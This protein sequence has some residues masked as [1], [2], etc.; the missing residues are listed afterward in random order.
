MSRQL[1]WGHRIPAYYY[2]DEVFVAETEEEA[3]Q[4]AREHFPDENIT[5]K[6]LKQDEDVLD[7]WF[8]S[9]L[10]PI[11]VFDGFEDREELEYY[12]PTSVLV[13]AWDIIFLWVARMIMAGYEWEDKRPF[14]KVY[15]TGM[16]RDKKRRKM[17]KSLGNS[18]DALGLIKEYGADAVRFGML[19][20]SPAGGDLLYD[21]KL[22]EQGSNFCNKMWN[23]LRLIKSWEVSDSV[24]QPEVNHL[25]IGWLEARLQSV[26]NELQEDFEKFR[27]SEVVMDLYNFIW[28]DFCSWFLELIKPDYEQP[29]DSKTHQKAIQL[30]EEIMVVLHPFMPFISEEI[31]HKLKDREEGEDCIIAA[32]PKHSEFDKELLEQM[33]DIRSIVS[34][35]REMRNNK[36]ISPRDEVAL[37]VQNEEHFLLRDNMTA[38]VSK[39]ANLSELKVVDEQPDQSISFVVGTDKYFIPMGELIDIEAEVEKLKKDLDYAKGFVESV[40]KKLQN[41]GFVNNAPEAVVEKERKKLEDGKARLEKIKQ[42]LDA[43]QSS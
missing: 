16:V 29:I 30:F 20:S 24:N 7:T 1:W 28:N 14:E 23:A 38:L 35:V 18:P 26:V 25:A 40:E 11:S 19:S 17:S 2:K 37:H 13:T 31:W 15:F 3:L 9:W 42:S 27:L 21:E 5:A 32:Y 4:Q 8:S 6:D 36:G 43:L 39:M 34:K 33:K 41:E 12:Y 22:I 10:W